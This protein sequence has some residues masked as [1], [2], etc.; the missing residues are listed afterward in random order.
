MTMSWP[1]V[2]LSDGSNDQ[3]I[4]LCN[5]GLLKNPK[6]Q[7]LYRC[8]ALGYKAWGENQKSIADFSKL[9]ELNPM[10]AQPLYSDRGALYKMLGQMA[11]AQKD[12]AKA[13]N[14]QRYNSLALDDKS[15]QMTLLVKSGHYKE[16]ERLLPEYLGGQPQKIFYLSD[17]AKL[18]ALANCSDAAI[19]SATRYL[20]LAAGSNSSDPLRGIRAANETTVR[21]LLVTQYLK[22]KNTAQAL[23]M[24]NESIAQLEPLAKQKSD[25]NGLTS[26]AKI[27]LSRMLSA[28]AEVFIAL[29]KKDSARGD[30]ERS[31]SL[32]PDSSHTSQLLKKIKSNA[33]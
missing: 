26:R 19:K 12:I 25:D 3:A 13:S 11:F 17:I 31:L 23:T 16:A 29:G 10:V 5:K 4:E 2:S 7:V 27:N 28:R 24:A 9:I 15:L 22:Q 33:I 14:I 6:N 30:L 1:A 21:E 8:R 32:Y 20:Q 18:F